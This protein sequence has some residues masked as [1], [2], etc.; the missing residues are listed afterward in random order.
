MADSVISHLMATIESR[1]ASQSEKSYTKQLLEGGAEK[2]ARKFGEEAIETMLAGVIGDK[3]ALTAE[4]ADAV[5]HLLVLLACR[6]VTWTEVEAALSARTG[7]SGLVEKASRTGA[8]PVA[9]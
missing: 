9:K 6:G 1:R 4:A 2:C 8:K 3:S 7:Q 5:Y